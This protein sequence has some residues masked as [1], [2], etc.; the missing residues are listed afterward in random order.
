[1]GKARAA[2]YRQERDMRLRS[3]AKRGVNKFGLSR[4]TGP[5]TNRLMSGMTSRPGVIG[6][7]VNSKGKPVVTSRIYRDPQYDDVEQVS[8][9][10]MPNHTVPLAYK[11]GRE[12]ERRIRPLFGRGTPSLFD[13]CQS[14]E[15]R[16]GKEHQYRDWL[17]RWTPE[18]AMVHERT[19]PQY[20]G[21]KHRHV[22]S[23]G[24]HQPIGI[25]ERVQYHACAGQLPAYESMLVDTRAN[26]RERLADEVALWHMRCTEKAQQVSE[27]WPYAVDWS[28]G[29]PDIA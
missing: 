1:M 3:D 23:V 6:Y 19:T 4:P 10:F 18:P 21:N 28:S 26:E 29:A 9:L 27:H 13:T 16:P 20:Q 12:A 24:E 15:S 8:D 17:Y 25:R 14:I 7:V 11:L 2:Q 22:Y 5:K